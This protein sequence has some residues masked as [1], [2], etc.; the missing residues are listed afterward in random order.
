MKGVC[1]ACLAAAP[2]CA[3]GTLRRPVHVSFTH[4]EEVVCLGARSLVAGMAEWSARPALAII[5]ERTSMRVIEGH[6]G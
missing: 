6:S 5:D 3:T 1:A 2:L 4:G